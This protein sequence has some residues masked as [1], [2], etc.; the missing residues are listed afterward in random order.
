MGRWKLPLWC[1]YW[2][3]SIQYV[4]V[5]HRYIMFPTNIKKLIMSIPSIM[6]TVTHIICFPVVVESIIYDCFSTYPVFISLLAYNLA[7]NN[8]V[9]KIPNIGNTAVK[10]HQYKV[11]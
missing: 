11:I 1:M 4:A 3:G 10:I 7:F 2:C 9:M 6:N 5:I 8:G